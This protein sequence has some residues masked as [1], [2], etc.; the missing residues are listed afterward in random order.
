MP[1]PLIRMR[2]ITKRFPGVIALDGVDFTLQ[3][4]EVHALMGENGAGKSTL[5]KVLTGA[6][7]FE[8]GKIFLGGSDTPIVN[9]SPQE[10]QTRG[11]ST[12]YQE[13]NLCPNLSVAE[14]LFVGRQPRRLAFVRWGEIRRRARSIMADIGVGIDVEKPL[15]SYSIAVQQMVAIGRAIDMAAQ[16][17]I[18]DEPTSSLNESEV[19]TL[20]ELVRRLKGQGL[21]IVFITHFLEQVYEVCDR[22]TVLRNGRLAG[23]YAIETLP[24]KDL[25]AAMLGRAFDDLAEIR[26]AGAA[27][28]AT[29]VP[30]VSARGLGVHGG[31]KPFD[32]N[33]YPGEVYGLAGLLGSGRTEVARAVYGADSHDTGTLAVKGKPI[34]CSPRDSLKAGLA[35][36]P[37]SRKDEG[38]VAE[39]TV[40][41]NIVLA[42]QT[43][44]GA[45]RLIP[46]DEQEAIAGKYA[47]LLQ[48]KTASLE[49]PIKQLSGGN[50]QK[51]ILARWLATQPDFLIL[52]EPTRGID[53][54]TKTEIQKLCVQLAAAGMSVLFISS[55]IDEMLRTCGRIGVM[56]DLAK[57]G[58]LSGDELSSSAVMAQIAGGRHDEA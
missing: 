11:I 32:L 4:G 51:V 12:V 13:V 27:P 57:V 2:G 47:D 19:R 5:V 25:V 8:E 6:E 42:E 41:E 28:T 9:H 7:A 17:L 43:K 37:E 54:G 21:G 31:V 56:R 58:E 34:A 26:V 20:F 16:V 23:E 33:I 14:N 30:T 29:T 1:D 48:I 36:C 39:L 35:F 49:T 45:F 40:R 3:P 10:A 22:I 46:R 55:E 53:I 52:D 38:C 15:E 44:R 18:L 50:Q 24:R